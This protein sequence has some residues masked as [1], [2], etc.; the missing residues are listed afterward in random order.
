MQHLTLILVAA[1]GWHQS[2]QHCMW[3]R[4]ERCGEKNVGARLYSPGYDI[5]NASVPGAVASVPPWVLTQGSLWVEVEVPSTMVAI[6]QCEMGSLCMPWAQRAV[7][8]IMDC[9]IRLLMFFTPWAVSWLRNLVILWATPHPLW[10]ISIGILSYSLSLFL[11]FYMNHTLHI[12]VIL[13]WNSDA[14]LMFLLPLCLPMSCV[15]SDS[16]MNQCHNTH[17][18]LSLLWLP[19]LFKSCNICAKRRADKW[20]YNPAT[21]SCTKNSVFA[22]CIFACVELWRPSAFPN[23]VIQETGGTLL[24]LYKAIPL[25]VFNA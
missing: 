20:S 8:T 14:G 2:P 19:L 23:E 12:I 1:Q 7:V 21:K 11:L 3:P 6:L 24:Q 25:E 4:W 10:C 5:C 9:L 18:N 15:I 16:F 17:K 13:C 22:C